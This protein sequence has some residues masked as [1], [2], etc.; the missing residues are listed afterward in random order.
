MK[1]KVDPLVEHGHK[2][3][4]SYDSPAFE[5][6]TRTSASGFHYTSSRHPTNEF[7]QWMENTAGPLG[8]LWTTVKATDRAGLYIYFYQA[9]H[10]MLTKLTWGGA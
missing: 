8:V 3:F 1:R 6:R 4:V 2:V 9:K 10:A 7:L 5:I